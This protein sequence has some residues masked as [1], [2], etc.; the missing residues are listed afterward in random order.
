MTNANTSFHKQATGGKAGGKSRGRA[1]SAATPSFQAVWGGSSRSY[2][3]PRNAWLV[4]GLLKKGFSFQLQEEQH[5]CLLWGCCPGSSG[6]EGEDQQLLPAVDEQDTRVTKSD[7]S[8]RHKRKTS[9]RHHP[10]HPGLF[11]ISVGM[12]T[13]TPPAHSSYVANGSRDSLTPFIES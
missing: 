9:L 2:L 1:C 3:W 4:D 10:G 5:L 13:N 11:K 7:S 12:D 8:D 6:K